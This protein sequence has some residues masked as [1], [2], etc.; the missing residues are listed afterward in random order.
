MGEDKNRSGRVPSPSPSSI[1]SNSR[2]EEEEE[3]EADAAGCCG[4]CGSGCTLHES[5]STRLRLMVECGVVAIDVGGVS[6]TLRPPL[7]AVEV[8]LEAA[9]VCDSNLRCR[10]AVD[11]AVIVALAATPTAAAVAVGPAAAAV[12]TP[13]AEGCGG[14]CSSSEGREARRWTLLR[15]AKC[16][17]GVAAAAPLPLA[18]PLPLAPVLLLLLL[19]LP[20]D[21]AV[22]AAV[23]DD[24][25]E[26]EAA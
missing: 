11:A 5:E 10:T 7:A 24:S 8:E 3:E 23:A 18:L 12:V 14:V 6:G 21:K 15:S 4:W 19:P 17:R 16:V 9:G 1:F 22:G 25:E 2:E 20:P 26:E 13:A